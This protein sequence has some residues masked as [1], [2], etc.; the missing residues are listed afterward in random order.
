MIGNHVLHSQCKND[1][2]DEDDTFRQVCYVVFLHLQFH[3]NAFILHL[4]K[5]CNQKRQ[6]CPQDHYVQYV[7]LTGAQFNPIK[8]E[9]LVTA[10]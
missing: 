5:H 4:S 1:Q 2:D 8:L 7:V 6:K 10:V 9:N 3:R